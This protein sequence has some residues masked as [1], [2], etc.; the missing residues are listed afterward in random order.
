MYRYH[1]PSP[2]E[3]PISI[4]L[5]I[6]KI[7]T[8]IWAVIFI[9]IF[10]VFVKRLYVSKYYKSFHITI[11]ILSKEKKFQILVF[12]IIM[13]IMVTIDHLIQ[14]QSQVL[15]EQMQLAEQVFQI[16]GFNLIMYYIFKKASKGIN[17]ATR[18]RIINNRLLPLIACNLMVSMGLVILLDVK[19]FTAKPKATSDKD[20]ND[21]CQDPIFVTTAGF[22][23]LIVIMFA[24]L[25]VK[26]EM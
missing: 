21:V 19:F 4:G 17:A 2:P 15:N 11:L 13:M 3:Q 14:F 6:W 16:L 9:G 5:C 1:H 7:V 8:P 23:L 25:V 20:K 24:V 12:G 10:A 26:L 22:E 18:K